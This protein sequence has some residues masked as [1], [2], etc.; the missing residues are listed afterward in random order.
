MTYYYHENLLR[1]NWDELEQKFHIFETSE[2]MIIGDIPYV[3]LKSENKMGHI[4][5][6]FMIPLD[7]NHILVYANKCPSFLETNVLYCFYQNIIDGAS[8]KIACSDRDYL[9][10]MMLQSK[11]LHERIEKYGLEDKKEY[12]LYN[13]LAF[14]SRFSSYNEFK[15]YHAALMKQAI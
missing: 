1:Y 8:E 11:K 13:I 15:N 7:K 6:E 9:K 3:P 12:A 5:E 10:Q 2:P 4:L 14:E